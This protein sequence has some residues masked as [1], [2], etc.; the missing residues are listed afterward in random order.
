METR[1]DEIADRIYRIS[2]FVSGIGLNFNQF[3]IDA[4]EPMLFHT[5]QRALFPSVSEA[6]AHVIDV[7]RFKWITFSTWSRT[8]AAL[9][10]NGSLPRR[11]RL[12]RTESSAA[13]P[14]STTARCVSRAHSPTRR[15]WI[16]GA[17]SCVISILRTF[18]IPGTPA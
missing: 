1:V 5:G 4:D 12:R 9:S 10:T 7:K 3:L 11:R 15:C 17:R 14:G 2:T 8:S 13:T 16:S 6:V 18:R